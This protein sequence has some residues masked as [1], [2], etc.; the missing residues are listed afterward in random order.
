LVSKGEWDVEEDSSVRGETNFLKRP[1]LEIATVL[2]MCAIVG[3]FLSLALTICPMPGG[4]V[5]AEAGTSLALSLFIGALWLLSR[6]LKQ[7]QSAWAKLG[8][9]CVALIDCGG[10]VFIVWVLKTTASRPT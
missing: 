1:P 6:S 8:L 4:V 3:L 2:T 10:L 7:R 5:L 9:L